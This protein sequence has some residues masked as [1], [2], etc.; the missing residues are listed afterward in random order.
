MD[1]IS[2][3]WDKLDPVLIPENTLRSLFGVSGHDL[4]FEAI[5]LAYENGRLAKLTPDGHWL[6]EQEGF[7]S[8]GSN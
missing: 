8:D 5:R 4:S 2:G 3:S 7:N 6:F 1:A